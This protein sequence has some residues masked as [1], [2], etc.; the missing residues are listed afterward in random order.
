LAQFWR[1]WRGSEIVYRA[2]KTECV[3]LALMARTVVMRPRA[4]K[5]NSINNS[6]RNDRIIIPAA[7]WISLRA[8]S[9]F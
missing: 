6:T 7:I 2:R 8:V 1:A 4:P 5:Q 3:G 9:D